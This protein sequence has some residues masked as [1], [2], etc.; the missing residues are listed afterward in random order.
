MRTDD[1]DG[2]LVG[3]YGTVGTQTVELAL[4]GAL[5]DDA[6]LGLYREA[7]EGYVIGDADGKSVLRLFAVEIV[8]Y[9]DDLCRSRVL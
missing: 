9:G 3:A 1:L 5:L 7:P 2:V 6:D 8:K 4:G